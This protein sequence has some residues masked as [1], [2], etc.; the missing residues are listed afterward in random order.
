MT[1][2]TPIIITLVILSLLYVFYLITISS[3]TGRS[4]RQANINAMLSAKNSAQTEEML[5]RLS[6]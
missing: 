2:V 6:K 3:I 4:S 5:A 1:K